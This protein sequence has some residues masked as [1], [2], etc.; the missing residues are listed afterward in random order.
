MSNNEE[1]I[2]IFFLR[3]VSL[4]RVTSKESVF[5]W[6][7]FY[8]HCVSLSV[9]SIVRATCRPCQFSKTY[10]KMEGESTGRI[11]S[12]LVDETLILLPTG[13]LQNSVQLP[14]KLL[15]SPTSSKTPRSSRVASPSPFS[16]FPQ[17][18]FTTSRGLA[19]ISNDVNGEV[20]FKHLNFVDWQKRLFPPE[21]DRS[22][23]NPDPARCG[24]RSVRLVHLTFHAV[25]SPRDC[26]A[27]YEPPL[28]ASS[29]AI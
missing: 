26:R 3:V 25:P 18:S 7:S 5:V 27:A 24:S 15:S 2:S 23:K 19:V 17:A 10:Y 13:P 6:E 14:L 11:V 9:R 8:L 21:A 22:Q 12:A 28:P 29:A 20:T 1:K 16:C 4:I